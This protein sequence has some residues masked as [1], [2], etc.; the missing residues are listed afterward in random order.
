MAGVGSATETDLRYKCRGV[1]SAA[2]VVLLYTRGRGES[3]A[4]ASAGL[5]RGLVSVNQGPHPKLVCVG[6]IEQISEAHYVQTDITGD[7]LSFCVPHLDFVF[8]MNSS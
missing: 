1:A 4:K 5:T 8:V 6:G 7:L 2:R 3:G